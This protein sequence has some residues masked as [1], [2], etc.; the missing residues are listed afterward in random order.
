MGGN[1]LA[2][3]SFRLCAILPWRQARR[4]PGILHPAISLQS[5]PVW[6]RR[7]HPQVSRNFLHVSSNETR[8][9]LYVLSAIW[10]WQ[11]WPYKQPLLQATLH[12]FKLFKQGC[13]NLSSQDFCNSS[14]TMKSTCWGCRLARLEV[15][16]VPSTGNFSLQKGW[17]YWTVDHVCTLHIL[18]HQTPPLL[19]HWF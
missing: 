7:G 5:Q 15:E 10:S 9:L 4:P 3:L 6:N 8:H 14:A 18:A 16:H 17:L 2:L 1:S 11:P 12:N 13:L 19:M